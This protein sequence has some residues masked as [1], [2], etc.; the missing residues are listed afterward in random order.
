[1]GIATGSIRSEMDRFVPLVPCVA[2]R[3]EQ[4]GGGRGTL[5]NGDRGRAADVTGR[6]AVGTGA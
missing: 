6:G 2:D 1:M 3:T 4:E 5:R